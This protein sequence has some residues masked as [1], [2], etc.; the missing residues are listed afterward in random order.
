MRC[1]SY[2]TAR[3]EC[4]TPQTSRRG[5]QPSSAPAGVWEARWKAM[6]CRASLQAE[7]VQQLVSVEPA[8]SVLER[9]ASVE[10]VSQQERSAFPSHQ[11]RAPV[12]PSAAG[13]RQSAAR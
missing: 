13:Q 6:E 5:A 12:A 11:A 9:S 3:T 4:T 1:R 2:W 10:Q 8:E 7:A